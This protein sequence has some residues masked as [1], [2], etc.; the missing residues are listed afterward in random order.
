MQDASK[1]RK[2]I[3]NENLNAFFI[4]IY[5]TDVFISSLLSNVVDMIFYTEVDEKFK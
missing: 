1:I 5:F 2:L 4:D 3:D